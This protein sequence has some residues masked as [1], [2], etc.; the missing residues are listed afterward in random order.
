MI[1]SLDSY[2][3]ERSWNK[4]RCIVTLTTADIKCSKCRVCRPIPELNA[5]EKEL[6][7]LLRRRE[8]DDKKVSDGKVLL[9][10]TRRSL[11]T[12]YRHN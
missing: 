6:L 3:K 7:D 4:I 9:I 11:A 5:V 2:C 8:I 1:S 12:L 10:F